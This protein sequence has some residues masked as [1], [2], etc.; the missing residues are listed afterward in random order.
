MIDKILEVSKNFL[1][2]QI[3]IKELGITLI[4]FLVLLFARKIVAK[5]IKAI[6]SK[7][8]AKTKND[9]DDKLIRNFDK[10]MNSFMFVLSCCICVWFFLA[11]LVDNAQITTF[12]S[13]GLSI[14]VL[15]SA[16]I[17]CF[18]WGFNNLSKEKSELM[19]YFKSKL[20]I[21]VDK[22][23]Y[24]FIVKCFRV[25]VMLICG[26]I[27]LAIWDID[28]STLV[29]GLGLGGLAFSLAAKDFASNIIGGIAL[30]MEK[31]FNI[32][33]W[34]KADDIEGV[35]EDI[36]FRSTRIR[37]FSQ[38]LIIAPNAILANTSIKNYTRRGKRR[39]SFKLGATYDTT[40]EQ[41]RKCIS[42]I[43]NLL[44]NHKDIHQETIFVAFD[45]FNS[46]SLD[47]F[48]Y[49]FTKTTN[50]AEYLKVKEDVNFEIMKIF[51]DNDIS[52]AFPSTS[53]YI[54]SDEKKTLNQSNSEKDMK[55]VALDKE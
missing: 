52:F 36:T 31:P 19:D 28:I 37:T 23:L 50:L 1:L 26:M 17:Y 49:F 10:P 8:A 30:I 22:I 20:G 15:Q 41:L 53:I 25:G 13:Y 7:Y 5:K 38:E 11:Q 40:R 39:I 45:E 47:I 6:F 46:S 33:D 55:Y 29:A 54:E 44:R 27:M 3:H 12:I 18:V 4:L 43:D 21:R 51:E 2:N 16:F 14:K 34:I 24:P 35:V 48:V 9:F 32:G 42:D